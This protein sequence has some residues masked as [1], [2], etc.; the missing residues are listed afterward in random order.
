MQKNLTSHKNYTPLVWVLSALAVI[1]ILATNYIPRTTAE[2]LFGIE[3][4]ILPLINAFLNGISFILLILAIRAIKNGNIKQHRNFILSAFS[5]T[6]VFLIT[7]LTY[8]A[9]AGSTS[10]GGG[11]FMKGL[12]YFVLISHIALSTALLPLAFFTL[13]KGLN[14]QDKQHRKFARWTMPIWLYVSFTGV[15][16]YLLISP[17]Y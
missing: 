15:L 6:F 2:T 3:L 14:R 12:Y 7:Y 5:V 11:G 4:T 13:A 10:F 16:V 1:I 9:L 8:H 17:Y